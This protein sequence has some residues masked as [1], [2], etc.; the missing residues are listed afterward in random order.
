[1]HRLFHIAIVLFVC[2]KVYGQNQRYK[3]AIFSDRDLTSNIVYGSADPYDALGL[4]VET[5]LRLDFYEPMGDTAAKRPLVLVFFGGAYLIGDKIMEDMVAWCDSLSRY[6]YACASV[7][8]R[9][10]FNTTSQRSSI[11]AGYRALQDARAAIR[12]FKHHAATYRI[13]TNYI[14]VGGNSAGAINAIQAAYGD[15]GDRPQ[16]TYAAFSLDEGSDLG[17]MDC[18]GNNYTNTTDVAGIIGCWGAGFTTSALDPSDQAPIIMFHGDADLI[19]PIDSGV[20]FNLP[21]FPYIYGSRTI[22]N[23][24]QG[25]GLAS[26]LHVF[27]GLGHNFYYDV[28]FFPNQYWDSIW[29]YTHPFL[30]DILPYCQVNTSTRSILKTRNAIYPNPARGQLH[31]SIHTSFL[32]GNCSIYTVHGVKVW[33][34]RIEDEEIIVPTHFL[35]SGVYYIHL[36]KGKERWTEK[37]IK[38]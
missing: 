33:E 18:S 30:C 32:D 26:E 20:P 19:V 11:R 1:M 15:D 25:M 17:C 4:T 28:A 36:E 7:N 2:L 10:G 34:R 22:H 24:R 16:E 38:E 6:G 35:R 31:C 8:Y 27:P 21:I 3:S 5:D 23:L 12:F 9:I 13:D 14:F 29:N 37:W